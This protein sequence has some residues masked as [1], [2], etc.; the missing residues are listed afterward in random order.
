MALAW[1]QIAARSAFLRMKRN[2]YGLT[3]ARLRMK[4]PGNRGDFLETNYM[5]QT[6][7]GSTDQF[8]RSRVV[9]FLRVTLFSL[10]AGAGR[11]PNSGG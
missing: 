3:Y 10:F 9:I 2:A 4:K 1:D 7:S 5:S 6:D 8:C 11:S